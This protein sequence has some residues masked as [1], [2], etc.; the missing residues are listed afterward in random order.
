M[1]AHLE[2]AGKVP[3]EVQGVGKVLQRLAFDLAVAD[4][5]GDLERPLEYGLRRRE[6]AAANKIVRTA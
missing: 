3:L 4:A 2:G 1:L 5:P 6:L